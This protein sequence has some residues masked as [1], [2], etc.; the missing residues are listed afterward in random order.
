MGYYCIQK[1]KI[2]GKKF[3]SPFS[4]VNDLVFQ[5]SEKNSPQSRIFYNLNKM[6]FYYENFQYV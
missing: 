1:P 2:T 4:S 6:C 5:L 3:F